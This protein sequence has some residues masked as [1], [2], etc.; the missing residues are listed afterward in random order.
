MPATPETWLNEFIVNL[1][2]TGAQ[3]DPDIIQLAN[4]NI[5]VSWTTSDS[6]GLGAP[7]GNETFAQIF[8]PVGNRIGG[9]IRLNNASTAD[10]EQNADLAA[11]PDGGFVVVYH[12]FDNPASVPFGGSNIRLEE[13][14]ANGNQVTENALVVLDGGAGAD[15]NYRNPRVAVSS[16]T[17]VLVVYEEFTATGTKIAGKIYNPVTDSYGSQITLI[18]ASGLANAVPD[19]A[20]LT[21]GNYVIATT[22]NF[23]G[24]NAIAY[25]IITS[26]GGGFLGPTFIPNTSTN[27]FNDRE[28]SVAALA[29]GGFVIAWT[30]TDVN[31]TD[32]LFRVY[33]NNG[34]EIGS[35]SAGDNGPGNNNNECKVI[36]LAD[37]TFV[38]AWDND[39]TIGVDVQHYSATGGTLGSAFT[40]TADNANNLSGVGLGDGRFALVW[41]VSGGEID[42]EILDTRDNPNNPGVYTPDQWVVGT[43]GDDGFAVAANADI[44]HGWDGNDSIV[45]GTG[46]DLIFGGTGNDTLLMDDFTNPAATTGNDTGHG[47]GGDDLLWGYGGNDILYGGADNDS[48]VGN[49]YGTN[50]NGNDQLY[51]GAGNDIL[52]VGLGGNAY[53]DGG[54][55]NDTFFGGALADILRG[56]TGNDYLYGNTGGDIFQFYQ[57]DFLNGDVDIVYFV[58]PTDR[59]RFSA[60]LNGDLSLLNTSLEYS[61]GL[62]VNSVYITVALGGGQTSAIAVYGATVASLTPLI[63]YTL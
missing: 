27:G 15:P 22:Y 5:L 62:F 59:L 55:G 46:N 21:S 50:V 2:T 18:N 8:D 40:V 42:M 45:G 7:N 12:D 13:Y 11:L 43:A 3:F 44:V 53:M 57:A 58:D 41:D 10:D 51:G 29:Q 1:T 37:G 34:I 23:A 14:D 28:V 30:N 24:D 60:S 33:N 38:I 17:S 31:D 48:L 36:A 4:G 47:D 6:G 35:G 39:A 63:E 19:V 54:S 9:E 16:D 52:F 61:P 20:V 49:D 26:A 56:G 32:I 25:T